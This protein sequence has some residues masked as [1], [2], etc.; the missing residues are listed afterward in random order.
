[1]GYPKEFPDRPMLEARGWLPRLPLVSLVHAE[2]WGG[3]AAGGLRRALEEISPST[4]LGR[5]ERRSAA[6]DFRQG[7]FIVYTG[8]GKGKTTAA[9]G[10]VFRALGHG[11]RTAVV[12]FLKGRWRTGERRLAERLDGVEFFALGRGFTWDS[13]DLSLDRA[14]AQ[15]AW[16]LAR[17]LLGSGR[18]DLVV[19]DEVT[20]PIHYGFLAASEL[21]RALRERPRHLHVVATGRHAPRELCE[22]A[23]LVT[24]MGCRKHP[25][26]R[27]IRAVR[28][29]DY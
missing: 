19:L 7:L 2:R 23:D 29:V 1:V 11:L 26:E 12:Q 9:L 17:E 20:Y 14:A 25:I 5:E 8:D 10:L 22:A 27:G 6:G 16:G 4:V 3:E 28:G 15:D 13:D 21:L 24:E 18:H